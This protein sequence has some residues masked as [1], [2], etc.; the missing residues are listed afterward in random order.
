MKTLQIIGKLW[1]NQGNTYHSAEIVCD[2]SL[3]T[4][5][6]F[7]LPFSYGYENQFIY[8]SIQLLVNKG[9]LPKGTI[10]A[11]QVKELGIDLLDSFTYCKKRDLIHL[12]KFKISFV[13]RLAGSIGKTY[14]IRETIEAT[15]ES[16][17]IEKLYQKY[18]HI[19][20]LLIK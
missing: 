2:Y 6:T 5:K 12:K 1:N 3:P 15:N 7:Y 17:A 14:K 10:S 8:N 4:E 13:G 9:E 19:T 20:N 18:E 11:R 16:E